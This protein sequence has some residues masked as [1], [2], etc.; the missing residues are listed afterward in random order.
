M[1][2]QLADHLAAQN[3]NDNL[4]ELAEELGI[5]EDTQAQ[6]RLTRYCDH[7]VAMTH[8][9]QALDKVGRHLLGSALGAGWTDSGLAT[10]RNAELDV[11]GA[12]REASDPQIWVT[13]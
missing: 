12:A 7:K 1:N 11:A 9:W 6:A 10:K 4:S 5:L 2:G 3:P 8:G 13:T